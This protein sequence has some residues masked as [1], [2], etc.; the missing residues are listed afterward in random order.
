[1]H[2]RGERS[3]VILFVRPLV[4]FMMGAVAAGVAWWLLMQEPVRHPVQS[5][6]PHDGAAERL[7]R[8]DVV[9]GGDVAPQ[10]RG[11]RP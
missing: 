6:V 9:R 5:G 11:G 10:R 4:V 1:M 2:G 3:Q 7:A 8:G